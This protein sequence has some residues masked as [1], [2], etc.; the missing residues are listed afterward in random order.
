MSFVR[1]KS[2]T[3]NGRTYRYAYR[4]TSVRVGKKVRSIMEY[5]GPASGGTSLSGLSDRQDRALAT[6]ERMAK[7]MDAYQRVTFGETGEERAAREAQAAQF[8]QDKFLEATQSSSETA[9]NEKGPDEGPT[10]V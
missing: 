1:I 6:A 4:Q 9:P 5:I 3:K 2:I 8:D 10:H 7:E